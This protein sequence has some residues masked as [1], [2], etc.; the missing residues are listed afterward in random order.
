MNFANSS[1][2]W[3]MTGWYRVAIV[4][5]NSGS[6][7]IFLMVP[8]MY[9]TTSFG[10]PAGAATPL[11]EP[12]VATSIPCSF[13]V[14]TLGSVGSR[15]G[16]T[17]AS[18]LKRPDLMWGMTS[19]GCPPPIMRWPP[20]RAVVASAPPEK[21]TVTML[22]P[23]ALPKAVSAMSTAPAFTDTA[24]VTGLPSFFEYSTTS[25]IEL[26]GD[27]APVTMTTE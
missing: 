9:L 2:P 17:T 23:A 7:Q 16:S 5:W 19:E 11:M 1:L 6:L 15:W 12:Q 13:R 20:A 21:G 8:S 4:F 22:T 14:G 26:K 24:V 25:F 3:Y 10:V 27:L 18:G